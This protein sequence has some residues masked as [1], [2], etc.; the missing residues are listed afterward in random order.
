MFTWNLVLSLAS[1]QGERKP[2]PCTGTKVSHEVDIP[3]FSYLA[4]WID[5]MSS[6]TINNIKTIFIVDCRGLKLSILTVTVCCT[7]RS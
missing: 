3:A 5:F 1:A 7:L 4:D 6:E 2:T